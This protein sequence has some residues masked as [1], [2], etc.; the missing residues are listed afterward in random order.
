VRWCGGSL[1]V[2]VRCVSQRSHS[3]V[4]GQSIV[5]ILGSIMIQDGSTQNKTCYSN[6]I[7]GYSL[8]TLSND[9]CNIFVFGK[10]IQEETKA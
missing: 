3:N 10:Y 2:V 8:L 6:L 4:N 7:C 1:F 5:A 9:V